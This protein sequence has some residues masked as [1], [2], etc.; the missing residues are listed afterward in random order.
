M[1]STLIPLA[2]PRR[3]RFWSGRV[4]AA[5][6]PLIAL[7]QPCDGAGMLDRIS[8]GEKRW[9]EIMVNAVADREDGRH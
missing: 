4:A 1:S 5:E 6:L 3:P 8:S 7:R 9:L 2:P